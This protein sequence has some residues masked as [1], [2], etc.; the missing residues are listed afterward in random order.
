MKPA[1]IFFGGTP[2]GLNLLKNIIKKK[3][4]IVYAFITKEAEHEPIKV[5]KDILRLCRSH[6][7]KARITNKIEL[8]DV[9]ALLKLKA[10]VGFV[11]GWRTIIPADLYKAIPYGCLAAHDSLLPKYRGFAPTAWA[12]INGENKTGVTLFKI[13]DQGVDAGDIFKQKI[14]NIGRKDTAEKIY[15]R[16][17]RASVQLYLEFLKAFRQGKV[18]WIKQNHALATFAKRRTPDDGRINWNQPARKVFDFIR[19]LTPPYP[20]S[21]IEF[22]GKR[23]FIKKAV[24]PEKGLKC[25]GKPGTAISISKKGA[26]IACQD[27]CLLIKEIADGLGEKIPLAAIFKQCV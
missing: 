18:K 8:K 22:Q 27:R 21:W 20:Y 2:R 16:I 11:C 3:E 6:R 23:I 13:D 9:P 26:L 7:I 24:L 10:D 17:V 4:N 25:F 5:S 12:I 1:I 15:P 14:I 19:A